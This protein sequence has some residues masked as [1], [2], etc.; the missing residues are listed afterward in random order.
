MLKSSFNK[1]LILFC[2][3]NIFL[4]IFIIVFHQKV[5][6]N[7][8]NYQYN[9]HQYLIDPRVEGKPFNLLN[10]L[11]QFDAQW[12]L[13]IASD[14]Y[15]K[16]PNFYNSGGKSEF[17]GLTYAFFPLYP[18]L[19]STLN[20]L[21]NNV[22]ISAFLLTNLLL[23]ANF[24]SLYFVLKNFVPEKVVLKT[25]FLIFL[26]PF[27]IFYR[28]Y[29]TEG[30]FLLILIWFSYFFIKNKHLYSSLLLGL[31][32]ITR[33]SGVLIF[34]PFLYYLVKSFFKEKIKTLN[35]FIS[36]SAAIFP[37]II[38]SILNFLNTNDSL[39]FLKIRG[40]WTKDS[41]FFDV[42]YENILTIL[43]F[44]AQ[45]LHIF[46][47]SKIDILVILATL[48]LLIL[49]RTKIPK[50]LWLISLS[51]FLAPL[52]F[53]DTMSYSRMQIVSF[54]LFLYLGIVAL[55]KYFFILAITFAILLF[56]T[57]LLFVNWY[58]IG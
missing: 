17:Q 54:P 18:L 44:P 33:G 28:S 53:N 45:Q 52:I 49:S 26:F 16:N 5:P 31:L 46:H 21:I 3:L 9:A 12:Y 48:I 11:A 32:N 30:L 14:G 47:T 10:G 22:L 34:L 40:A 43:N 37:I 2:L 57:S 29:F 55:G 38:W 4:Y 39:F 24:I 7:L 58:W 19:L 56:L 23:I 15:P 20:F 8:V 42:F 25:I 27:S 35:Y 6:F 36:F 50:K 1:Y 13:K 41:N 51:L